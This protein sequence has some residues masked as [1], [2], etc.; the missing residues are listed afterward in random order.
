MDKIAL[1]LGLDRLKVRS[2]NLLNKDDMPF[3]TGL[4]NRAGV[5]SFMTVVIIKSVKTWR[6]K[7]LQKR[8]L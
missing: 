1:E 7:N 6:L 3:M 8:L 2:I 4:K 5:M